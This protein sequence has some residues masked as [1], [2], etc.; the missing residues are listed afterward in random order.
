MTYAQSNMRARGNKW[1]R[2]R[3]WRV[4]QPAWRDG[5]APKTTGDAEN[6]EVYKLVPKRR[7]IRS[8]PPGD[9]FMV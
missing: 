6:D 8:S 7:S 4:A 3:E 2:Y 5:N 9:P 1:W